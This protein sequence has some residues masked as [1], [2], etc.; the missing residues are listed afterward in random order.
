MLGKVYE[1]VSF[2]FTQD[3]VFKND[4]DQSD[5]EK[6]AKYWYYDSSQ[7]SLYLTQ[8]NGKFYLESTKDESGKLT[9]DSKSVNRSAG[10][11]EKNG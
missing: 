5:K 10:N 8:D 6:E 9:T 11:A 4:N 2:P 3:A 1:N 7:S